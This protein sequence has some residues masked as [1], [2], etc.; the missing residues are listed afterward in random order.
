MEL[1]NALER[2][3]GLDLPA[4]LMFDYPTTAAIAAFLVAQELPAAGSAALQAGHML[5]TPSLDM[6]LDADQR[7]TELVTLSSRHPG[8]S[9]G[10]AGFMHSIATSADLQGQPPLSRWDNDLLYT[11]ELTAARVTATTRFAA[12][13]D[14]IDLFDAAAFRLSAIEA[15]SLDPQVRLVHLATP[16]GCDDW[17]CGLSH[18]TLLYAI[19][20]QGAA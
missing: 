10:M 8:P 12:F 16:H 1:R 3:F 11:P 13:C 6:E 5:A 14:G 19:P 2:H 4:T 18:A 20:S 15:Y 7:C 9:L 17:R